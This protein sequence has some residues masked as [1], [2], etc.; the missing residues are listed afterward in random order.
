MSDRVLVTGAAGF[1]GRHLIEHL[2][3]RGDDKILATDI[4]ET[5]PERYEEYVG[6]QVTYTTG[7]I[8]DE[9]FLDDLLAEPF[10]RIYHFAAVVGVN[11]YVKNPLQI[12][13]VNIIATHNILDRI[14][15]TD[16]RF[17]FTSTSEVY[18][19]NPDV[20]WIETSNRVTGPP[21][22][23]RWSYSTG[24]GAAEHMIHGLA[25]AEMPFTATVIR[26]FN[27]YGPGQ[28]PK[29]V[30]PAFVERVVNDEPPTVYDDGTQTRCFTYINDFIQG[31]IQASTTDAGANE[32]FN[33]GSTRETEI[34]ELAELVIKIAGSDL[35]PDYIDTDELYGDSYE[36]L[37]RRVP[38]TSKA[39][40]LLDWTAETSLETGIEHVLEWGRTN[41]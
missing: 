17:V 34:H 7:D 41:Y 37:D 31:V 11:E 8:T 10:D 29:F 22:V 24:K 13:E 30:L 28:R 36:D 21:T 27:L 38:D 9:A 6:E 2:V 32:V 4:V 25:S 1:V 20:P 35:K 33:L 19:K 40:K 3:E 16:V 14:K 26:P 15:D 5:P 18:G 23:D 39:E 12:T